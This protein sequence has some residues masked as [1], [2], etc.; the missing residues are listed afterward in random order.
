[1]VIG[2]ILLSSLTA[3]SLALGGAAAASGQQ[4]RPHP[5][6]MAQTRPPVAALWFTTLSARRVNAWGQGE[7]YRFTLNARGHGTLWL[8]NRRQDRVV[9]WRFRLTA[10]QL[11]TVSGELNAFRSTIQNDDMCAS[12]Q[13][14]DIMEWTGSG[15]A[16]S[17]RH[18][19][20]CRDTQN[21]ERVAHIDR[22]LA[23]LRTAAQ[24]DAETDR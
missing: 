23:V 17:A 20:G 24:A 5:R 11:I 8:L 15:G 22:A 10:A 9:A 6:P 21:R 14:F 13:A 1:M 16:G 12:D 3:L 19:H 7:A 2:R 4:V 18:D